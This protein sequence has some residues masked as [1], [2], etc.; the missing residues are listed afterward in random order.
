MNLFRI[1]S[2]TGLVLL[3]C[4]AVYSAPLDPA[5]QKLYAKIDSLFVIASSGEVKYRDKVEPATEAIVKM[6][7]PAVP[8]LIDKLSTYSARERVSLI[9]IMTKIGS[10]AV[11][12]LV[13]ALGRP[14]WLV[15]QRVCWTLGDIKD[16]SAIEPLMQVAYNPNWQVREYCVRALGNIG[17]VKGLQSVINAFSDTVGAVRKAAA[18]AAGEMK[19]PA[20]IPALVAALGDDFYGARFAAMETLLKT[21]T[22]KVVAALKVSL[23]TA[24]SLKANLICQTLGSI[25]TGDALDILNA[26]LESDKMEQRIYA[27]VAIV[28]AD[29]SDLCGFYDRIQKKIIDRLAFVQIE[30]A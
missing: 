22:A 8:R 28:N 15:V 11:P 16:S 12:K 6:G 24:G 25:G 2:A 13:E 29:P 14:Q 4:V 27:A 21:D 20:A 9:D 3:C 7:A 30:S 1:L 18:Y 17:N 23:P 26:H 19:N 5:T 10:P